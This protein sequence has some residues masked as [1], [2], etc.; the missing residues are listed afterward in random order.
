MIIWGRAYWRIENSGTGNS[1]FWAF[2][3][4]WVLVRFFFFLWTVGDDAGMGYTLQPLFTYIPHFS[5]T[6]SC[7]EHEC[8]GPRYIHFSPQIRQ[9]NELNVCSISKLRVILIYLT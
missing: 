4:I 6:P 5:N 9:D 1:C 2:G 8:L 3:S 7:L